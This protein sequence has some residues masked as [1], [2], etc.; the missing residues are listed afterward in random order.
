[1][2]YRRITAAI[3][4]IFVL[5]FIISFTIS[6]FPLSNEIKDKYY[7]IAKIESGVKKYSE[8]TVEQKNEI[9]KITFE[10]E[11]GMVKYYIIMIVI[12]TIYFILIPAYL[13]GQTVGQHIRKVRLI[14]DEKITLNTY[15]IRS[16]LNSG[17]FLMILLSILLYILNAIWYSR[18]E[19]ILFFVQF[20]YWIVCFLM[21]LIKGETI[22]DKITK[23][24][25]IEVKR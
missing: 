21:L 10:I 25:V 12:I 18:V 23:T 4:D 24:K 22:H 14:S 2:R 6:A 1:M 13:N 15:I 5:I 20:I 7:E 3:L 16:T 8:F 11:R 19:T 17:L 9:N